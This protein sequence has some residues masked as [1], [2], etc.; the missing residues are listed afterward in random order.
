[1]HN[2]R[3]LAARVLVSFAAANLVL[4]LSL[5]F[6]GLDG[7]R[8]CGAAVSAAKAG[9]TPAPR[10]FAARVASA[11][12]SRAGK[13]RVAAVGPQGA[14]DVCGLMNRSAIGA[15]HRLH[16]DRAMET[17]TKDGR[18]RLSPFAGNATSCVADA[19]FAVETSRHADHDRSTPDRC[20]DLLRLMI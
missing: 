6:S 17:R 9:G 14:K 7:Y 2:W 8:F 20:I 4:P 19:I 11:V 1:M 18:E 16:R 12:S 3:E 10:A 13:L 15:K 5:L